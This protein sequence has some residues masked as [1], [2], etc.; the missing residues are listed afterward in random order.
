[1]LS[2]DKYSR[3]KWGCYATSASMSVI[4]NLAPILFL[5]FR[6]LYDISYSLLGLLVLVNFSTQLLVDLWLSFFSHKIN[7]HLTVRLTPVI[8]LIGFLVFAAAP[9]IF[10]NAVYVGLLLGTVIYSAAGGL[11]EVLISPVIAAIPSDNSEREV[12]KLHSVYA[13][14]VVVVVPICSL[15]ILA[16][17]SAMWQWLVIGFS[18]IPLVAA[19]LL[20]SAKLPTLAT[21]ERSSAAL[22]ELKN[23]TLLLCIFAIF[24]G[25]A[26]ECTMSQWASGYIEEALGIDKIWG[27]IFGVALF[28]AMLGLGRTLYAKYGRVVERIL[29]LGAAGAF[30]CYLVSALS[31]IPVIGLIACALTGL[32]T[33]MLWPGTL[34]VS[35]ERVPS[36]GV[37]VYAIMASG[38]DLGASVGPQLV[39]IITDLV[40]AG[41]LPEMLGMAPEALGM[42]VGM[43]V[44]A[45][46]PLAASFVFLH[47]LRT[48]KT[49]TINT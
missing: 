34:I 21:T 30:V 14:G 46:F 33:S 24:L 32:S 31:P 12:S 13:W 44:G 43:L 49:L 38:G 23:P 45:L 28:G 29:F 36:G 5:G 2:S 37:F 10:P 9:I 22:N 41:E 7:M 39:G 27:D 35:T 1:M 6:D 47:L 25:G 42:K 20:S 19:L 18:V 4:S 40:A 26:S 17:T 16:F 11:S 8:T 3:A 48:R 15:F